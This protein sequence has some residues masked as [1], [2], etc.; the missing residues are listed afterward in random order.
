[1]F[2]VEDF[3][4]VFWAFATFER[5]ALEAAT[6]FAFADRRFTGAF[7]VSLSDVLVLF[8]VVFVISPKAFNLIP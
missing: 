1:V 2:F 4:A 6:V 7:A 3:G 5:E 8:G